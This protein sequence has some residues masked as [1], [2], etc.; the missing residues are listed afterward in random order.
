M[1]EIHIDPFNWEYMSVRDAEDFT[2]SSLAFPARLPMYGLGV[3]PHRYLANDSTT[4][5]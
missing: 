4:H 1:Y 5:T 2:T 3:P